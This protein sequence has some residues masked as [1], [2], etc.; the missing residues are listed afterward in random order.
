[1]LDGKSGTEQTLHSDLGPDLA[2]AVIRALLDL[3]LD[4]NAVLGR[5]ESIAASSASAGDMAQVK[6]AVDRL[7]GELSGLRDAVRDLVDIVLDRR[8]TA[9]PGYAR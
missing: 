3:R 1:M 4:Q 7:S 6:L 5:I 8:R 9:I 2:G